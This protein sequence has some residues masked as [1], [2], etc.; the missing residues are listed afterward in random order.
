MD[1][2]IRWPVKGNQESI[3]VNDVSGYREALALN[4]ERL[5]INQDVLDIEACV[6]AESSSSFTQGSGCKAEKLR[7]FHELQNFLWV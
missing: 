4:S 1:T 5:F 2:T 7:T 6:L 3:F